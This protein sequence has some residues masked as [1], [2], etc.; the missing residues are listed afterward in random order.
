[1]SYNFDEI[2]DQSGINAIKID[3]LN[4]HFGRSDILPFWIADMDFRTP[5]FI[6][7]ALQKR[8]ERPIFG[9]T[10]AGNGLYEAVQDWWREEYIHKIDRQQIDFVSGVVKAIG[11][12]IDIFTKSG[13]KIIIQPPVYHP[14]RIACE[15]NDRRVV[16]NSLKMSGGAYSMDFDLLESQI[17]EH[18][19]MMILCH[20]HN[21]G[22][23]DWSVPTLQ[24]LAD[25]CHKH[26]ILV[27]S[28]EIH[29]DLLLRHKLHRPFASV[30]ERAAQN[31]ITLMSGS[32]TF[33]IAGFYGS[34]SVIF[35]ENIRRR[36]RRHL[37]AN[38][39]S[40]GCI[41]SY[42]SLEAAYR[43]GRQWVQELREYLRGNVAFIDEYLRAHI[44]QIKPCIPQATYLMWL[45]CRALNLPQSELVSLFVNRAGLALN[46]GTLFGEEGRGFMRF[47]FATPR[48]NIAAALERLKMAVDF[49]QEQ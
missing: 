45:D 33:N 38:G 48:K 5:D 6:T 24:T 10:M 21:P 44:P 37:E 1:M 31:S 35:N 47:N 25:I 40:D 30:S 19:K 36:W 20:P 46:D 7:D 34:Y 43:K 32:K 49:I 4:Q 15:G 17:D 11:C 14:F 42:V 2:T 29:A 23:I 9:Y 12:C 41:F 16:C 28:D 22:G 39:L 27:V 3:R 18:C 13:D 26:N 8:L